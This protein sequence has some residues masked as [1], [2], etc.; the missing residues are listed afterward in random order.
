MYLLLV[1]ASVA[2]VIGIPALTGF[3]TVGRV[4]CIAAYIPA[5]IDTVACVPTSVGILA[6]VSV[7]ASTGVYVIVSV[8]PVPC[9]PADAVIPAVVDFVLLLGSMHVVVAVPVGA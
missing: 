3:T 7:P 4:P 5:V 1:S 6:V 8:L 2:V 9:V